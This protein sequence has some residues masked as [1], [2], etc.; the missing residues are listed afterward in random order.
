MSDAERGRRY[1]ERKKI[2]A[3]AVLKAPGSLGAELIQERTDAE[4]HEA[5]RQVLTETRRHPTSR[6]AQ[7]R[8]AAAA[9]KKAS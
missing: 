3:A 9:V 4:L 2:A 6:T 7:L 8:E 5:L 1:R